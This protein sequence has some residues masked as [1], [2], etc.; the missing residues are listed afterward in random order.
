[1]SSLLE[2]KARL[3]KGTVVLVILGTLGCRTA[4]VLP[5]MSGKS[6]RETEV[7]LNDPELENRAQALASFSA[8]VVAQ[9]R[10]DNPAALEHFVRSL[11]KDPSNEALALDVARR[12][13]AREQPQKAH[14][15]LQRT[16]ALPGASSPAKVMLGLACLQL[17]K[18]D[19]A[20]ALYRELIRTEPAQLGHYAMLAQILL[21]QRQPRDAVQ[22]VEAASR[23]ATESPLAWLDLAG[24]FGRIGQAEPA[25][26][27]SVVTK[28]RECLRKVEAAKPTDSRVLLRLAE[29]YLALGDSGPAER[30]LREAAAGGK[31]D[32]Q[33]AARL[34]EVYLRSGKLPEARQQFLEMTRANPA[35]PAPHYFLG[36]IALEQRDFPQAVNS[37]ERSILLNPDFEAAY[38]DLA[39]AQM[40]QNHHRE[41]LASLGKARDRFEGDFRRELLAALCLANLKE[42]DRSREHFTAAEKAAREKN[43]QLLDHRFYL[44]L[45]SMLERA[46]RFDEA[47]LALEQ[48]LTLQPDFDEALNHLGYMWAERGVNLQLARDMIERALKAEPENPAYLDSL[49]WV[50]FQLRKPAEALVPLQQAVEL[51]KEPDATVLDHLGDVLNALGRGDEAKAA[52]KKSL[53]VESSAAVK[54]K[55]EAAP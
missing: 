14:D 36:I 20:A 23:Q 15:I 32:P 2:L 29:G 41:A 49:G 35:N 17:G 46:G 40:S 48:S 30:V 9:A 1:M 53:E 52:W 7:R 47:V 16:V 37:L 5:G 10:D 38:A 33:V 24:L 4:S 28:A 13:L 19:A 44:Q 34:A 43:P 51:L 22:I 42:F 31:V 8:G 18:L 3:S 54:Q 11:E 39:V 12:F 6:K 26:R 21:Q 55:L 25:L 45:G 50:L 27:E